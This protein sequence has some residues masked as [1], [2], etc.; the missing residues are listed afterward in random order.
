MTIETLIKQ[1]KTK[2]PPVIIDVRSGP[3]YRNGHIPGA[4]HLPSSRLILSRSQLPDDKTAQ[5]VI[6]CEHGPRASVAKSLLA[7]F[8]YHNCELLE[9]HMHRY[10][11]K[12]LSLE[13]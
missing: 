2:T 5:L 3:E 4:L 9:G 11:Q 6:T 10:R 12:G 7:L 8:G 1:R 13:K